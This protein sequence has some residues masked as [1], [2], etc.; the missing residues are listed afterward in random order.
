MLGTA[1]SLLHML[2]LL[3]L[4]RVRHYYFFFF[5]PHHWLMEIPQLG[6]QLALQLLAYTTA[7]A[8]PDPSRICDLLCSL[9]QHWILNPLS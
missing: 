1:L 5:W 7:I 3:I 9:W 2:S 4:R 8:M 6:I